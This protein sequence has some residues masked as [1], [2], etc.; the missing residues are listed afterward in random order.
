[1]F[2]DQIIYQFL[3]VYKLNALYCWRYYID[4]YVPCVREHFIEKQND[5]A[6]S[7]KKGNNVTT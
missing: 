2:I 5:C 4:S 6:E 1:M 7:I 3:S